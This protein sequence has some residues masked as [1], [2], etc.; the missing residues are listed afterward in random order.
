MTSLY[1][2]LYQIDND[3]E[4]IRFDKIEGISIIGAPLS[5]AEL[6]PIQYFA[7]TKVRPG[8]DDPFEG[9]GWTPSE[10]V[11]NLLKELNEPDN[12]DEE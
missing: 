4:D 1:D 12:Q 6:H 9:G 11:R 5:D 7:S 8:D 10:A 2:M 3:F